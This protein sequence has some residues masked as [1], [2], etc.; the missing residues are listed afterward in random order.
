VYFILNVAGH[1]GM[2]G[3]L[4]QIHHWSKFGTKC[5][6]LRY[7]YCSLIR[8]ICRHH[9]LKSK[10]LEKPGNWSLSYIL[11]T[12][13][14]TPLHQNGQLVFQI[15]LEILSDHPFYMLI[16]SLKIGEGMEFQR[17]ISVKR[18]LDNA[19]LELCWNSSV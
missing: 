8:L 2:L 18:K 6:K 10:N 1:I 14:I 19:S 13:A 3:P 11:P 12:V 7:K 17:G 9:L 4:T 16:P 5:S 15:K